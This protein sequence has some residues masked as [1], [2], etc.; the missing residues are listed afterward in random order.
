MVTSIIHQRDNAVGTHP[1]HSG[2]WPSISRTVR[3]IE[4]ARSALN[5]KRGNGFLLGVVKLYET[6][7][8]RGSQ[9]ALH[10]A[11]GVADLELAAFALHQLGACYDHPQAGATHVMDLF[12]VEKNPFVIALRDLHNGISRLAG[13]VAVE[14]ATHVDDEHFVDLSRLYL[15]GESS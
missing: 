9:H 15:H 8:A 7:E 6:V 12:E 5:K 10:P 13:G 14:P 1:Y 11:L 2:A 3:T 4:L